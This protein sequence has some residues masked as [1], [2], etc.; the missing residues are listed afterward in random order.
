MLSNLAEV[1]QVMTEAGFNR[2]IY[3]IYIVFI[4]LFFDDQAGFIFIFLNF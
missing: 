4:F 3:H 2:S 1:K